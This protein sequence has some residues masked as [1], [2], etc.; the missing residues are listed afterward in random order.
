ML[1][2]M[3]S[4]PI[5]PIVV[6][7]LTVLAV[8]LGTGTASALSFVLD[9]QFVPVQVIAISFSIAAFPILAEAWNAGD[10]PA[11]RRLVARNIA[12]IGVLTAV[13]AVILAVFAQ[14]LV[15]RLLGGGRFDEA[16]V[17]LT[18]SLLVA[19]AISIPIDSLSY[20]LSRALYATHN[21][22]WQVASS[23]LGLGALVVAAQ[24]LVPAAGATGIAFAYAIGGSVKLV[25]LTLALLPR[26][27]AAGRPAAGTPELADAATGGRTG[28]V[29]PA[30]SS[31]APR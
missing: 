3:L 10:G 27:R 25:G 19:F 21:T 29:S 30:G 20:P 16:A 7:Y 22:I 18:S 4:Y 13:A 9:Y 6:A 12:T 8:G 24:L 17:A 23:L 2:R 28:R 1:P 14:P 31:E 11:F 5:D 26:L 15:A